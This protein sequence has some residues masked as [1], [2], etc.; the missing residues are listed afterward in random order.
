MPRSVTPH[1]EGRRLP[2]DRTNELDDRNK[3]QSKSTLDE[4]KLSFKEILSDL[5]DEVTPYEALTT[6]GKYLQ[7]F[8]EYH[9]NKFFEEH[10]STGYMVE[11]YHPLFINIRTYQKKQRVLTSAR[12]FFKQLSDNVYEGL[13]FSVDKPGARLVSKHG[14][15]AIGR[16]D[17]S[18]YKEGTIELAAPSTHAPCQPFFTGDSS[19][20]VLTFLNAPLSLSS[21]DVLTALRDVQGVVDVTF[22]EPNTK[23]LT[24]TGY[25]FF[26]TEADKL[27]AESRHRILTV[28]PLG[29]ETQDPT[30]CQSNK[31]VEIVRLELM[32]AHSRVRKKKALRGRLC[33]LQMSTN[34]RI[35]RD[36]VI[37]AALIT[38][39]DM[40]WGVK[41]LYGRRHPFLGRQ[42]NNDNDMINNN[43]DGGSGDIII[44][45]EGDSADGGEDKNKTLRAPALQLDL[46]ILYIRDVYNICYYSG[47]SIPF[48]KDIHDRREV[49]LRRYYT[50]AM[51]NVEPPEDE[52]LLAS[53]SS[54]P[55]A[56]SLGL[57]DPT[58]VTPTTSVSSR[59]WASN[60]ERKLEQLYHDASTQAVYIPWNR[61][62]VDITDPAD[63]AACVV[64][65]L[66]DLQDR[67]EQEQ[68]L[69]TLHMGISDLI[70]E[71]YIKKTNNY[72][73]IDEKIG[74][75]KQTVSS[76]YCCR[77]CPKKFKGQQFLDTHFDTF[78]RPL[79]KCSLAL[80]HNR[81]SMLAAYT[82][83]PYK[84]FGDLPFFRKTAH[85]HEFDVDGVPIRPEASWNSRTHTHTH[86]HTHDSPPQHPRKRRTYTRSSSRSRTPRNI[87]PRRDIVRDDR[88]HGGGDGERDWG[89]HTPPPM[90][91]DKIPPH[92]HMPQPAPP[93][94]GGRGR[95]DGGGSR[96]VGVWPG[97]NGAMPPHESGG[98]VAVGGVLP[99][100]LFIPFVEQ[101]APFFMGAK[102]RQ[103]PYP[104][105]PRQFPKKGL[106]PLPADCRKA[107]MTVTEP[108]YRAAAMEGA[109][110][111]D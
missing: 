63:A 56:T 22:C 105:F 9:A 102:P 101:P 10:S 54:G 53:L 106:A 3:Y 98:G 75:D 39:L 73:I 103:F 48:N 21:V 89:R 67:R 79:L 97:A 74:K 20:T 4:P 43:N 86:T 19:N 87:R 33:P 40:V 58:S 26:E 16:I 81:A 99:P 34:E 62:M 8:A 7:K 12:N 91:Y 59:N 108:S 85:A 76:V 49:F 23:Q 92:T 110:E 104:Q 68:L 88:Q 95:G 44:E 13:S 77:E 66:F 52:E 37:S 28:L 84:K 61:V 71:E 55:L 2:R 18:M 100:P 50:P 47:E 72:T 45:T 27:K 14:H 51:G 82:A 36:V 31:P 42:N 96:G 38:R 17:P 57:N 70:N 25:I 111:L 35:D 109:D 65:T 64:S 15:E 94:W 60:L 29:R 46:Q 6:Y 90:H 107:A 69:V 24:R 30:D 83:D 93:E 41:T 80:S 5:S 11:K 78:H 1:R 32:A